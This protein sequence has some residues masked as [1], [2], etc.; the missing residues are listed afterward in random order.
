MSKYSFDC[1]SRIASK[2][3]LLSDGLAFD[4]LPSQYLRVRQIADVVQ[5]GFRLGDTRHVAVAAVNVTT[6]VG[7]LR[8]EMFRDPSSSRRASLLQTKVNFTLG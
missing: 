1:E 3:G 5:C 6:E 2:L 4:G 7:S 8:I